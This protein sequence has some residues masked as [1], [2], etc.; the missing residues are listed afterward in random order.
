MVF[1]VV[2]KA[3]IS[4]HIQDRYMMY[5]I[6]LYYIILYMNEIWKE[7]YVHEIIRKPLMV[8][9]TTARHAAEATGKSRPR[10]WRDDEYL[11]TRIRKYGGKMKE[12]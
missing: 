10:S 11:L 6:I 9:L 4:Y 3:I 5:Y 1:Y 7:N 8:D 12:L 2:L